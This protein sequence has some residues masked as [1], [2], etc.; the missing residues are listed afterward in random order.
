MKERPKREE[1]GNFRRTAAIR[2]K[3]GGEKEPSKP[4]MKRKKRTWGGG[5]EGKIREGAG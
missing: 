5:E 2:G 1:K 3:E 4:S